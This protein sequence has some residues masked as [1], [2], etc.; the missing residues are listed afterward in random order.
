MIGACKRAWRYYY[1][2]L[3]LSW[4]VSYDTS[5]LTG[6]RLTFSYLCPES[7]SERCC[8]YNIATTPLVL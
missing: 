4:T 8:T 2:A 3:A 7:E 1:V 5:P 6:S